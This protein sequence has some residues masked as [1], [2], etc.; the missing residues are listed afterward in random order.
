MLLIIIIVHQSSHPSK[1]FLPPSLTSTYSRLTS[2]SPSK[3]SPSPS[4][5]AVHLYRLPGILA[6]RPSLAP[7]S[8]LSKSHVAEG[9]EDDQLA[10]YWLPLSFLPSLA[11]SSHHPPNA[12]EDE[13]EADN[14]SPDSLLPPLHGRLVEQ[15]RLLVQAPSSSPALDDLAFLTNTT[16]VLLGDSNERAL[17]DSLCEYL[18]LESRVLSLTEVDEARGGRPKG[19]GRWHADPHVCEVERVG[20]RVVAFMSFG[21]LVDGGGGGGEGVSGEE[22]WGRKKAPDLVGPWSIEERI[23]LARSFLSTLDAPDSAPGLIIL[24]QT[25]WD[26]MYASDLSYHLSTHPTLPPPPS[27]AFLASSDAWHPTL[28]AHYISRTQLALSQ[29]RRTFPSS[30]VSLRTLHPLAQSRRSPITGSSLDFWNDARVEGINAALQSVSVSVSVEQEEEEEEGGVGVGM[31]PLAKVL[32]GQRREN[33]LKL[34]DR[35]H[36]RWRPGGWVYAEMM[37]EELRRVRRGGSA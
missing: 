36:L 21:V 2:S 14:P 9:E 32:Q 22:L 29:L 8:A 12:N 20:L 1:T 16:L 6:Y 30:P 25:L 27:W 15:L 4:P 35:V 17:V 33:L 28:L 37:F 13:D 5:S 23:D 34:G 19:S 18:G 26:L 10:P 11:N 31:M 7:S 3:A 24:S